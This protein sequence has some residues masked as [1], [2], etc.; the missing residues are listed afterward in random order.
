MVLARA[1]EIARER[2]R[3]IRDEFGPTK[4]YVEHAQAAETAVKVA[5][6]AKTG[7][8]IYEDIFKEGEM[9]NATSASAYEDEI[10]SFGSLKPLGSF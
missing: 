2:K 9:S 7:S 8:I 10:F 6:K 3:G 5:K 4:S 1:K